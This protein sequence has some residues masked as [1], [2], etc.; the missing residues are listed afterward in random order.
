MSNAIAG[1]RLIKFAFIIWFVVFISTKKSG[2]LSFD[3]NL[4]LFLT[5][6]NVLEVSIG[7]RPTNNN[8]FLSTK[9]DWRQT[10]NP[11]YYQLINVAYKRIQLFFGNL[12]VLKKDHTCNYKVTF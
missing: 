11:K 8:L 12:E 3:F 7:T 4:N 10:I 9:L 2:E 6:K 5:L 1:E